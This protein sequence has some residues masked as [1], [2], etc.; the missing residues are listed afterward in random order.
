M[1]ELSKTLAQ[2][3]QIMGKRIRLRSHC[4]CATTNQGPIY[5][6]DIHLYYKGHLDCWW[7]YL[8]SRKRALTRGVRLIP[9]Y[10]L[11]LLMPN[12]NLIEFSLS[13]IKSEGKNGAS[14]NWNITQEGTERKKKRSSTLPQKTEIWI[15]NAT[16]CVNSMKKNLRRCEGDSGSSACRHGKKAHQQTVC[17][18]S[19][20]TGIKHEHQSSG[21]RRYEDRCFRFH[22]TTF[23]SALNKRK[24]LWCLYRLSVAL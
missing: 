22:M 7:L 14:R 21:Q 10:Q 15:I 9:Q 1:F 24:G 19:H 2:S 11:Y 18:L 16:G 13:P 6:M 3:T 23:S 20:S 12:R 5:S 4:S 8:F 17:S